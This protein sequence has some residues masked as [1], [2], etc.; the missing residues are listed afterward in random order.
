MQIDLAEN[1]SAFVRP[2]FEAQQF[3]IFNSSVIAIAR[4]YVNIIRRLCISQ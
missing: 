3:Y 1:A 2:L 4:I